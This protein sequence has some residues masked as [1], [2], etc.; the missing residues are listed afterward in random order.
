MAQGGVRGGTASAR[1]LR[2]RARVCACSH[3]A[4][5][6][7]ASAVF[8]HVVPGGEAG[9]GGREELGFRQVGVRGYRSTVTADIEVETEGL[10]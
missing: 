7:S 9:F 5:A 3:E 2:D 6:N 10:C 1:R 8:A 4:V